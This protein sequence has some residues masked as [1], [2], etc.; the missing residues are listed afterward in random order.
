MLRPAFHRALARLLKDG[1][2]AAKGPQAAKGELTYLVDQSVFEEKN[3]LPDLIS[4]PRRVD[5]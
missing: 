3:A 1:L 5:R 4:D 2:L